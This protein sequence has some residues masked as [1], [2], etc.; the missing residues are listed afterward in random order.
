MDGQLPT[1]AA[2]TQRNFK[3]EHGDHSPPRPRKPG[4]RRKKRA[5]PPEPVELLLK[6]VRHFLGGLSAEMNR[7][8]DPRRKEQCLY[9]Q[10]HLLWLGILLFLTHLGSRRQMRFERLSETFMKNLMMLSGQVDVDT[11]ADPDTL[12]YYAEQTPVESLEKILAG[13]TRQLIRMK[14]QVRSGST[15][16]SR[17]QSTDHKSAHL[18]RSLGRDARIES[19]QT[20]VS[21]TLPVFS[22]PNWLRHAAWRLPWPV[23][24]SPTRETRSL[25]SRTVNSRPS[26]PG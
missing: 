16:I 9:S 19:F 3:T 23:R 25:T 24:C 6:T 20:A 17:L 22:T 5:A 7:L 11:V 2:D 13:M 10:A 4:R 26:P 15:G 18:I 14:A 8:P 12:A 1:D 21:S